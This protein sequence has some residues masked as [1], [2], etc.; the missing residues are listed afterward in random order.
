MG[1]DSHKSH[2]ESELEWRAQNKM[3]EK[4]L[5]G[6]SLSQRSDNAR[7]AALLLRLRPICANGWA[8]A[9]EGVITKRRLTDL[10]AAEKVKLAEDLQKFAGVKTERRRQSTVVCCVSSLCP[11]RKRSSA[12][13]SPSTSPFGATRSQSEVK[14]VPPWSS[15]EVTVVHQIQNLEATVGDRRLPLKSHLL[16]LVQAC[17][18]GENRCLDRPLVGDTPST[19]RQRVPSDPS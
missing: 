4:A 15:D 14:R 5:W 9:R 11:S 2:F 3:R 7:S 13:W 6:E 1:W 19:Y 8:A 12:F 18:W 16:A 17:G 10:R